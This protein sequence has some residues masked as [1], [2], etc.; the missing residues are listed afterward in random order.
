MSL[1]LAENVIVAGADNRPPMLDKTQYSSWAS[2]MLLYIRG[3][4]N[5]KLLVDSL[6][7]GPFKY[8]TIIVPG[9]VTTPAIVRDRTY[10][11]LTDVEKIREGC[12]IKATNIERESKLYDEFD[13][14]TSVP[15]D[16]HVLF[17]PESS[18]FVTDVK[19]SKDLHSTNFDHL[20]SYLRQHE[21]HAK[22]VRLT[23]KRYSDPIALVANTSSSSPSYS[24]QS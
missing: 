22:E 21:A 9:T 13:M 8:G 18:K 3:K 16:S 15:G 24:N 7:N 19:L 20:Y 14:F 2:R 11:E 6:L 1:S 4:E 5:V 17:K 23:R 10:D 12:D